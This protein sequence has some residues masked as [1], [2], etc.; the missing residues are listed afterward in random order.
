MKRKCMWLLWLCSILL[1]AGCQKETGVTE[2]NQANHGALAIMETESGYYYNAGCNQYLFVEDDMVDLSVSS[3]KHRLRYYDKENGKSIILCNKPECEHRGDDACAATYKGVNIINSVLYED[4]IYIYGLEE[5]GTMLRLNLYRAA[6]DGSAVDK[7]G[8]VF[9]AE[10]SIGATYK[11]RPSTSADEKF[12]FIIHKGS[13]YIP[14]YLCIG[15]TT[16][17][18]RGGGL[19]K[20]DLQTGE[21]KVLH[22]ME[23]KIDA[24]PGSLCG[25]GDYV[26]MTFVQGN[27]S[28]QRGSRRYVISQDLLEGLPSDADREYPLSYDAFAADRYYNLGF[29]YDPETGKAGEY[30]EIGVRDAVTGEYLTDETFITDITS[31]E[32][33]QFRYVTIYE[34]MMVL[35]TQERV[36]FYS[37]AEEN[38]GTKLGE[39]AYVQEP[40]ELSMWLPFLEYKVANGKL[41]RITEGERVPVYDGEY[42]EYQL[43]D[44]FCCP[45]EDIMNG[46][47]E[48][49]KAF[50][51]ETADLA[52]TGD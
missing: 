31:K 34:D 50:A 11:Y 47:G 22:E 41:Y 19:V 8:T 49:T 17:G 24:Y 9:E 5:D 51:Y 21:T 40:P 23:K 29:N 30:Y 3:N 15:E 39:I 33:K 27:S 7:V 43:Y 10:N 2:D 42:R 45:L 32:T 46:T 20:M 38:R 16:S 1:L 35:G 14:Y 48:W 37:L 44:V 25:C 4:R 26:Y 18:F 13:A 28:T 52:T 12:Y 36:V 6:L